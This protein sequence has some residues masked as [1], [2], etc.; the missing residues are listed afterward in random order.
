MFRV[1]H[2]DVSWRPLRRRALSL[3][4][5]AARSTARFARDDITG[6]LSRGIKTDGSPQKQNAPSTRE[7]KRRALGHDT[8]LVGSK[9]PILSNAS[10]WKINRAGDEIVLSPPAARADIIEDLEARGYEIPGISKETIEHALSELSR[11]RDRLAA[12]L[13]RFV[14]RAA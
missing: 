13:S 3:L 9:R 6:R 4:L 1:V 12:E 7:R 8:P 5:A 11:A 2:I 10:K 14:R